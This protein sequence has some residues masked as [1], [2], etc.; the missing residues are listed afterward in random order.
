MNKKEL[1]DA[2]YSDLNETISKKDITTVVSSVF[3]T[4]E[5]TVANGEKVTIV[6]FGTFEKRERKERTGHNPKTGEK[7][8]ISAKSVPVFSAGKNFKELVD[9]A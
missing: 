7:L 5:E 1:V 9:E 8:E 4:V 6:G 3:D 2:I